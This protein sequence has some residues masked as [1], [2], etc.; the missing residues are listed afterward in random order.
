MLIYELIEQN[1]VFIELKNYPVRWYT[2]FHL[3][4]TS[5]GPLVLIDQC[6]SIWEDMGWESCKYLKMG[7][8]GAPPNRVT[9]GKN[10]FGFPPLPRKVPFLSDNKQINWAAY[11]EKQGYKGILI[12]FL[13]LAA[14]GSL[15]NTFRINC[16]VRFPSQKITLMLSSNI[17]FNFLN[18]CFLRSTISTLFPNLLK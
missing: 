8:Y 17:E 13:H 7:S 9:K 3:W 14:Y 1:W 11:S 10:G 5:T 4:K 6:G 18:S 2:V 15:G 16:L 12:G